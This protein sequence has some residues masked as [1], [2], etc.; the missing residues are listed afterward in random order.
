MLIRPSIC[1]ICDS[2]IAENEER[3]PRCHSVVQ[4]GLGRPDFSSETVVRSYVQEAIDRSRQQINA[5]PR[6]GFA[7]YVLG[8]SY[9]NYGLMDQGINY[10]EQAAALLPEKD[11][12]QFELAVIYYFQRNYSAAIDKISQAQKLAPQNRYYQ[13]YRSF[14]SGVQ[15]EARGQLRA[16]VS[17]WNAAYQQEPSLQPA[18]DALSHFISLHQA[19]LHL[20]IVKSLRGL[21]QQ[22]MENLAVLN[23]DPATLGP[24][25]PR[26][27]RA[28]GELGKLSMALLR[29]VST[30]RAQ[31]LEKMHAE[32]L[33]AHQTASEIYQ[34]QYE[35]TAKEREAVLSSWRQQEQAIRNDLPEMARLCLAV[36]EEEERRRLEEE[37]R[38]QEEER[39]RLE[40]ERRKAELQ[41]QNKR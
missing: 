5:N 4:F 36:F 16:A 3:C 10:L 8:L 37:R 33:A 1:P 2:P 7:H 19:K 27:P 6:D 39:R 18:A 9:L 12:I 34:T 11:I 40:A 41:R 22:D 28:P 25:L 35:S 23:T 31:V 24:K 38:Q 21:S 13:Y 30:D 14:L 29:K 32:R 20:P 15:A 26:A 17:T